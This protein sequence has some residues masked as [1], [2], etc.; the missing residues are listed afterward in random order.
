MHCT[1]RGVVYVKG[2]GLCQGAWSTSRGV[3]CSYRDVRSAT[4]PGRVGGHFSVHL[5][6]KGNGGSKDGIKNQQTV[7][8]PA[9]TPGLS[10]FVECMYVGMYKAKC[11]V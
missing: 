8:L 2:C 9:V 7:I 10:S 3:Q 1:S 5:T 4:G 11:I 6:C